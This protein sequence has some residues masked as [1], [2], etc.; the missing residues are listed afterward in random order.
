MTLGSLNGLVFVSGSNG[1]SSF[2]VKGSVANFNAAINGL[3]YQP[4]AGF[5]GP[6]TLSITVVDSNDSK[7]GSASVALTVN[8][9]APTITAPSSA[10]PE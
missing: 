5:A 9:L 6:D 4:V 3:T 10:V 8:A 7:S 1:S 2:S